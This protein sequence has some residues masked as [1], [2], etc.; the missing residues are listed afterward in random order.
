MSQGHAVDMNLKKRYKWH[1][2]QTVHGRKVKLALDHDNTLLI[3]IPL[4]EKSSWPAANFYGEIKKP[5]NMVDMILMV[6]AFEL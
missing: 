4:D 1:K 6:L 5:E 2:E 3:T